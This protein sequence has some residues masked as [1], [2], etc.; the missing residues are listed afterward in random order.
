MKKVTQ[1]FLV[2]FLLFAWCGYLMAQNFAPYGAA[3]NT[4]NL[5]HPV[6]EGTSNPLVNTGYAQ[7]AIGTGYPFVSM[8]IPA[9][10]PWT[11][12]N[13]SNAVWLAGADIDE[14]NGNYYGC[15]YIGLAQS[16]LVQ[17]D[18]TTGTPTIVAP[19]TGISAYPVALAYNTVTNTWYFGETDGTTS[20]L[21][22]LN[23]AT[24][25]ATLVGTIFSGQ[26][27][28]IAIDCNGFAYGEEM[29]TDQL[30]SIDLSTGV[31][32]AIG[33]MGFNCTYAQDA[34][35]DAS[36]GILYLASYDS[37]TGTAALRTCDTNTGAT[38]VVVSWPG[39]EPTGFAIDNLCN[40]CPVGAPSNPYPPN[41]QTGV[42]L[43]GN[44]ATWTNGSGTTEIEL[45]FGPL[46]SL[47][48]V[49]AGSPITSFALPTLEYGTTYGW[50]VKD[51][52]G[53]CFTYGPTWTFTTIP[54]P[55]LVIDTVIVH[56]MSAQYWTGATDGATKTDGEI[57]TIYPN[58][59]WA[60]YDVSGFPPSTDAVDAIQF[61]GYVNATNWPYWSA[62]PMGSV[63]PVTADAATIYAQ[64][65]SGYNQG[66]AYIYSDESSGFAVGWHDYPLEAGATTDLL[67]AL[68]QGW[69]AMGFIDRD[70][71]SSFYLNFDG[72]SQTNPPYLVVIY[73][74]IVPV[75]LTSFTAK[76]SDG[77]VELSWITATETNNQGFEVQRSNGGEFEAI[78][79]V[80]GHGTT[81][82]TNAYSYT[83]KNLVA[84]AY[85]Y[86]LKQVDFDGTFEYSNVVEVDVPAPA[87]FA[88][89]QN[90]PNPFNPS[91]K[92][93]FRLAVD[94]K[95]SLKVFDVLGQEVATLLNGDF[96]AGSHTVNFNASGLNSGVYM[97]RIEA[98]GND[99]TNF[100][101]VK[102]MILTK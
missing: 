53:T 63:N 29:N 66:T 44:T 80:D 75:E 78:A 24:G 27:I 42:G 11:V 94:S 64:V 89:D 31:G 86:R 96:V 79:F 36:T 99:G 3:P 93:N 92:I 57:N 76:T 84:G 18:L 22:T 58:V 16:N 54:N 73:E 41:G 17:V 5:K 62:T 83:D 68:S 35:F 23:I 81:T 50:Y 51:G 40:P 39:T 52:D 43:T 61:F 7:D 55:N 46:G 32:T 12:L 60:V 45:Y 90:Y 8:P 71:S 13:P 10:T 47:A 2:L 1:L 74:Y 70:F 21:Y 28:A 25:A 56:P 85:S 101:S 49:Y 33:Y 14:T 9:G 69:F 77:S 19:I 4:G 97:Y 59:G 38:T 91:T 88:L 6:Y 100:T 26:L 30:Y 20:K 87:V 98:T 15:S 72:W 102:K 67:N 82:E 37:N 65:N 95:V 34:D 48:Q